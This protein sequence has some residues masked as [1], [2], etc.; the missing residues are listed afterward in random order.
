MST[1]TRNVET[2][3]LDQLGTSTNGSSVQAPLSCAPLIFSVCFRSSNFRYFFTQ[4]QIRKSG[5]VAK[6]CL[7]VILIITKTVRLVFCSSIW[8]N[9]VFRMIVVRSFAGSYL[10]S[11]FTTWRRQRGSAS[12]LTGSYLNNY[13][14]GN[15][16]WFLMK[17]APESKIR[18]DQDRLIFFPYSPAHERHPRY[19]ELDSKP[20]RSPTGTSRA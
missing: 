4:K 1:L 6:N 20:S 17:S 8:L 7:D 5:W 10:I 13:G 15:V 2:N 14:D 11:R 19:H 3:V 9:E 16:A 18:R 12:T